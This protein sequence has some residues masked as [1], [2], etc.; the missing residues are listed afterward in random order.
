M[1]ADREHAR[2]WTAAGG[3]AL[4]APLPRAQ[5]GRVFLHAFGWVLPLPVVL[6]AVLVAAHFHDWRGCGLALVVLLEIAVF[7]RCLPGGTLGPKLQGFASGAL[8]AGAAGAGRFA[9]SWALGSSIDEGLAG[10]DGFAVLPFGTASA[11]AVVAWSTFR[12]AQREGS[13]RAVLRCTI[14]ALLVVLLV[15]SAATLLPA[16]RID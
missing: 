1:S 14:G 15:A 5:V 4:G 8:A 6:L 7:T 16:A 13:A 3:A 10:I 11:F 9:Y 2:R 12:G